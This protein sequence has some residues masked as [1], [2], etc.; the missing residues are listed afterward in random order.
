VTWAHSRRPNSSYL[1]R[2]SPYFAFQF[3]PL[4]TVTRARRKDTTVKYGFEVRDVMLK[5]FPN[6]TGSVHGRTEVITFLSTTVCS[7]V[8]ENWCEGWAGSSPFWF[9]AYLLLPQIS[10]QVSHLQVLHMR[11]MQLNVSKFPTANLTKSKCKWTTK[12]V[13]CASPKI[14]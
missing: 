9:N 4:T 11:I 2:I 8:H 14:M 6:H 13:D 10:T 3:P 1:P 12:C 5:D 7:A